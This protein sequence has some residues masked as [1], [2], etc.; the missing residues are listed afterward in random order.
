MGGRGRRGPNPFFWPLPCLVRRRFPRRVRLGA[1]AGRSAPGVAA[2][3][4]GPSALVLVVR[5]VVLP[6]PVPLAKPQCHFPQLFRTIP[7][8]L[9][10][11]ILL[12]PFSFLVGLILLVQSSLHPTL[13]LLTCREPSRWHC[14]FG[15]RT[16]F[17]HCSIG[18]LGVGRGPGA[19]D[20]AAR[21]VSVGA[22]LGVAGRRAAA[23]TRTPRSG[24]AVPVIGLA[25][26]AGRPAV[27]RRR[28]AA[29]SGPPTVRGAV[30]RGRRSCRETATRSR[31]RAA[32]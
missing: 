19:A 7:A 28:A 25:R 21:A 4:A 5:V 24:Q 1:A 2:G 18:S 12:L 8:L 31:Q 27:A 9:L 13:E 29:G 14:A 22:L 6:L 26:R 3:T 10:N 30:P 17:T 11:L 15:G 32:S 20:H 23:R 16:G